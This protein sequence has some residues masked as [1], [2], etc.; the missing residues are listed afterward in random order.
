MGQTRTWGADTS[1]SLE[2]PALSW[3]SPLARADFAISSEAHVGQP[4]GSTGIAVAKGM[5]SVLVVT[6]S[7]SSTRVLQIISSQGLRLG[8]C[9]QEGGYRGN[10]EQ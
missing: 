4:K 5:E 2:L 8:A 9:R 10:T 1:C 6:C 7:D 3:S